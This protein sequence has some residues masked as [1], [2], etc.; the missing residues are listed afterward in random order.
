MGLVVPPTITHNINILLPRELKKTSFYVASTWD[1]TKMLAKY[2]T[3]E[4]IYNNPGVKR[5]RKLPSNGAIT[6]DVMTNVKLDA[7]ML[8]ILN[9]NDYLPKARG[10]S[11]GFDSFFETYFKLVKTRMKK[12]DSNIGSFIINIDSKNRMSM[13]VPFALKYFRAMLKYEPPEMM[14]LIEEGEG[15]DFSQYQLGFL[16]NLCEAKMLP[17]PLEIQTFQQG[18]TSHFESE[19]SKLN[20]KLKSKTQTSIRDVYGEEIEIVR[21]TLGNCNDTESEW[22]TTILGE[23]DGHGVVS[24][25]IPEDENKGRSYLFEV[26]HRHGGPLSETKKRLASLA[27]SEIFGKENMHLFG[28]G[29]SDIDEVEENS[30]AVSI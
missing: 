26:P 9:G 8:I 28:I 23:S 21:M 27:L 16:H 18:D 19:L 4:K 17:N 15:T 24:R 5:K 22:N 30:K 10:V 2:M 11:G 29:F 1:T 14:R 3:G 12:E 7:V 20:S 13:N 25:M 6:L